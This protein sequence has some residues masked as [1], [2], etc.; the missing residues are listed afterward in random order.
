MSPY[1]P[2]FTTLAWIVFLI[3]LLVIFRKPLARTVNILEDRIRRGASLRLGSFEVGQLVTQT[4]DLGGQSPQVYGD[5][6]QLRLLFKVQ[7]AEFKKSTKAMQ[8]PNGCLIQVS[9]ERR[10]AGDSW[11]V[12][13]AL[14]FV[15]G[16][17]IFE[18]DGVLTLRA[19]P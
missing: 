15:P 8:M 13:E 6:D 19:A 12:A 18:E 17:T 2:L 9:T 1:V 3:G 11:V 14:E 16:V 5:P 10:G 7:T 4:A